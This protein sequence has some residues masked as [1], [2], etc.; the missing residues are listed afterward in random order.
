MHDRHPDDVTMTL[1][2]SG[3]L[4]EADTAAFEHHLIELGCS[5][6]AVRLEQHARIEV[7]MH[8]A[9]D[10]IAGKRRR[11]APRR[12]MPA[13]LALAASLVL[14]L[15]LPGRWLTFD[16]VA[17]AS[18]ADAS[19]VDATP[20]REAPSCPVQDDPS[21]ELCDDPMAS[22]ELE[23]A[24]AMSMPEPSTDDGE[25]GRDHNL[26]EDLTGGADGGSCGDDGE[27]FSG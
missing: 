15:G 2:I 10:H 21:R 7:V 1:Y 6:C 18:T 23:G 11:P 3:A 26:C 14:G 5:P 8:E 19:L 22:F 24:L 16:G 27:L 4:G 12:S 9:A 17:E 20:L 25:Q 13:G